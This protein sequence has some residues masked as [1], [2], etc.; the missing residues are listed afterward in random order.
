MVGFAI[1]FV[2]MSSDPTAATAGTSHVRSDVTP[3]SRSLTLAPTVT[4][5]YPTT[6]TQLSV[7]VP[8]VVLGGTATNAVDISLVSK[9]RNGER[10]SQATGVSTWIAGVLL[11]RGEN[12]IEISARSRTGVVTTRSIV[13]TFDK[14]K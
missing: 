14:Q 11:E 3:P 13:V 5:T 12:T 1:L 4:V 6:A 2:G 9:F 10:P 8:Y 7:P